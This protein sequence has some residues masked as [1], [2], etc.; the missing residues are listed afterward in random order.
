LWFNGGFNQINKKPPPLQPSG[1]RG[2]RNLTVP[3]WLR[4]NFRRSDPVTPATSAPTKNNLSGSYSGVVFNS[5]PVKALSADGAFSL[6]RGEES[7]RLRLG[8]YISIILFWRI[9]KSFTMIFMFHR[10]LKR[11]Y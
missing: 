6:T 10:F 3:P 5:F 8:I 9:V 7:T 4:N 2:E 11:K 1:R